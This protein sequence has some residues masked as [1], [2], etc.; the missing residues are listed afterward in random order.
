MPDSASTKTTIATPRIRCVGPGGSSSL[1]AFWLKFVSSVDKRQD[2]DFNSRA[3]PSNSSIDAVLGSD[4]T[5]AVREA[6]GSTDLA[7][8]L[9]R[10]RLHSRRYE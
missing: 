10:K 9:R 5:T 6:T 4:T 1:A 3:F 8:T 7:K 2:V